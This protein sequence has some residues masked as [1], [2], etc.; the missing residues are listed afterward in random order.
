MILPVAG[1][2]IPLFGSLVRIHKSSF[3]TPSFLFSLQ[4]WRR[5]TS[6]RFGCRMPLFLFIF[7][8]FIHTYIHSITIHSSAS[9]RWSLLSISSSLVCS[10]GK[11]SLWCR[12]EN[13]TR[14]CLTASRRAEYSREIGISR[15]EWTIK[16]PNPK[17]RLS[18]KSYLLTD[19]AALCLTDFIDWR[20]IHIW[21][22]F[23]TQLVNSCPP[24]AKELYLCTVAP[25]PSL[26]PPSLPS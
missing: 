18:F 21:L 25:L 5:S 13:R 20:Y 19:I 23:S 22:V 10:V 24:W 4:V 6:I 14:A 15:D 11:T 12:A 8:I 7:H 26:W 16:T 1:I 3:K 9:I 2:S 17:C